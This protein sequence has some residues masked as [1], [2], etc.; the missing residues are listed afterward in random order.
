MSSSMTPWWR[1]VSSTWRGAKAEF[2]GKRGGHPS[3]CQ[4][5]I[6]LTLI[7]LARQKKRVLRLKGGDPFLFARGGEEIRALLE[8]GLA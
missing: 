5:D 6:S 3:P 2:A 8:A 7:K 4:S 1:G